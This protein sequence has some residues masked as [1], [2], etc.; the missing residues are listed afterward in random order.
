MFFFAI[1]GICSQ[2]KGMP[3]YRSGVAG[4]EESSRK[5]DIDPSDDDED[6]KKVGILPEGLRVLVVV[7]MEFLSLFVRVY[8]Q[9]ERIS[10]KFDV[11]TML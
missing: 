9:R 5:M 10:P 3:K 11:S 7:V 2:E 1:P 4:A 8:D 6:E